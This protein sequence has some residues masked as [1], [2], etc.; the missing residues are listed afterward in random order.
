MN[1]GLIVYPD[2]DSQDYQNLR[3]IDELGHDGGWLTAGPDNALPDW[4]PDGKLIAYVAR[5]PGTKRRMICV[6]NHAKGLGGHLIGEG[7]SPAWSPDGKLIAF[8]TATE[9]LG[10]PA[11]DICVMAPD[12]TGRRRVTKANG[13]RRDFPTW[14]PTQ[15]EI[16][17]AEINPTNPPHVSVWI[18][19]VLG[20]LP[21]RPLTTGTWHNLDTA[22][23][24]IN[25]ANDAGSP[26][27][28]VNDEITIWSGVENNR[29][30]IWTIK[31]NG[32]G[33]KQ[34]TFTRQNND[35]PRWSPDGQK[36]LFS[37]SEG[38]GTL[39]VL[40][41]ATGVVTMITRNT[42]GPMSGNGSWQPIP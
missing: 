3:L 42:A 31:P 34:L 38:G 9:Q 16:A 24:I 5:S 35:D 30:Q 7:T 40:D 15:Q 21:P 6:M 36:I 2:R 27:W 20:V 14:S 1:N 39:A 28:G 25:T 29:G 12:G 13:K 8:S 23:A 10:S 37:T 18:A 11:S 22:G 4:S 26:D 17:Y 33:R 41:V 32:S 19:D